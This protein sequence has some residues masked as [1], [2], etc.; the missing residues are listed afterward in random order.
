M[1]VDFW[2]YEDFTIRASLIFIFLE[3]LPTNI[4]LY[5]LKEKNCRFQQY[6]LLYKKHVTSFFKF[7]IILSLFILKILSLEEFSLYS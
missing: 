4:L 7:V 1:L 5:L 2:S 3:N 6:L